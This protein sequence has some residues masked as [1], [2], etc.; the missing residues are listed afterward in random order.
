MNKQKNVFISHHSKDDKHIQKLKDRLSAKGYTLKNSSIDSTKPNR[1]KNEEAIRRL[2][3]LRIHW[4]GTFICLIGPETH[5]RQWVD[6]EIKK[7]HEKGKNIIGV[8]VH[9]VKE[10][11]KVPE[12]LKRYGHGLTTINSDKIIDALEGKNIGWCNHQDKPYIPNPSK[13]LNRVLC[14]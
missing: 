3:R 4:A 1:L 14:Q 2:L 8:F 9:G 6:W 7:A 5:T 13:Q 12:N 11:S 10:N